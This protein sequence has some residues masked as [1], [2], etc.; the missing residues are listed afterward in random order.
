MLVAVAYQM[1]N[2]IY[3]TTTDIVW[4]ITSIGNPSHTHTHAI[5]NTYSKPHRN[6]QIY[7]K[8]FVY[9]EKPSTHQR[10]KREAYVFSSE[11]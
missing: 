4:H 6:T 10:E 11:T 1:V 7:R 9:I 2:Y 5:T 3:L 8:L